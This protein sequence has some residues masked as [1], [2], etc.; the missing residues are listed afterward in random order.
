MEHIE[1]IV[2]KKYIIPQKILVDI[3]VNKDNNSNDVKNKKIESLKKI[4]N[5]LSFS[6]I[7]KRC[8]RYNNYKIN[9]QI[10]NENKVKDEKTN[11]I[12]NNI[13]KQ[14]LNNIYILKKDLCLIRTKIQDKYF[15]VL[16][17]ED[18][19]KSSHSIKINKNSIIKIIN[20]E[21]IDSKYLSCYYNVNKINI[22]C[23]IIDLNID[24]NH[25]EILNNFYNYV[26]NKIN[27]QP[28]IIN[29]F[30]NYI[31]ELQQL[32]NYNIPKNLKNNIHECFV[33]KYD[34]NFDDNELRYNID[35]L[36]PI[37]IEN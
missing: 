28:I 10:S 31:C 16:E 6:F 18:S 30:F 14:L 25:N 33:M 9:K 3:N 22:M 37:Y 23:N 2:S 15:F 13:N 12:L 21:S 11:N 24:Y 27:K 8:K 17:A 1:K 29:N 26:N 34:G 35:Y 32:F 20:A 19:Y 4:Y 36:S 5:F 7:K